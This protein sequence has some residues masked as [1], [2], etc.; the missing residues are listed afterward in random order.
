[1]CQDKDCGC[2]HPE[3]LKSTP[4]ECTAEQIRKCHGDTD[5]HPCV[6]PAEDK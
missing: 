3:E 5:G 6:Q 1:M 4:A 2:E